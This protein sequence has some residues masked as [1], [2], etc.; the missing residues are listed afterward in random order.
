MAVIQIAGPA[1]HDLLRIFEQI[2]QAAG[3]QAANN[4][5]HRLAR[6]FNQ[7]ENF[8]YVGHARED[9][10]INIR[11]T[12]VAPYVILHRA[13][14]DTVIILRVLHGHQDV[15]AITTR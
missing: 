11:I 5:F 1:R 3:Y 6:R 14:S 8:S 4:F 13:T 15:A 7:L 2:S 12:T 9:Y 10:G